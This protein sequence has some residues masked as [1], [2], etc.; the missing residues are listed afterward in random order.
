MNLKGPESCEFHGKS[1]N[2]WA[3][4]ECLRYLREEVQTLRRERNHWKAN[5]DNQVRVNQLLRDRP[6]LGERAKLVAHLMQENAELRARVQPGPP[7]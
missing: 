7:T 1:P 3:C 6:D 2:A 4:P 5:H